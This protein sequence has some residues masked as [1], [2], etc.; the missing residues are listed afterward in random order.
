MS[1]Y[2]VNVGV[3][4]TL[5]KWIVKYYA[6]VTRSKVLNDVFELPISPELLPT[7]KDGEISQ[8]TEES[9]GKYD[10]HDF[11]LYHFLRNGFGSVKIQKLAEIAFPQIGADEIAK[12]LQIFYQRFRTQQFKRSCIPDGVKIGSVALSPRGDLRLPSDLATMY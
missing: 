2:A 1:N 3:P 6:E 8:K 7:D 9:I 12:T 5:V 4:K 10:L 11:F